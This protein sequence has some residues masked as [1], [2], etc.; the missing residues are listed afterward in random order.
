MS[1]TKLIPLEFWLYK[2][3]TLFHFQV[4]NLSKDR[5]S[6]SVAMIKKCVEVLIDKQY[7]ERHSN[8]KDMYNYLA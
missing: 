6:P 1:S 3:I 8:Q 2:S 7:L 5:F 4:I